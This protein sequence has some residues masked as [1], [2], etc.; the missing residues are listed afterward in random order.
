MR[1]HFKPPGTSIKAVQAKS[2]PKLGTTTVEKWMPFSG[3]PL[4]P[5]ASD[6]PSYNGPLVV[7][8]PLAF[9]KIA[10]Q[11]NYLQSCS[12]LARAVLLIA[13]AVLSKH[14]EWSWLG[15]FQQNGV[16]R[17]IHYKNRDF[18]KELIYQES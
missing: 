1:R 12:S 3:S 15:P 9:L 11:K 8:I 7:H 10:G 18:L 17:N 16:A 5:R 14:L 2:S 4:I 13:P 6:G